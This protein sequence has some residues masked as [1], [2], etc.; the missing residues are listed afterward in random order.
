MQLK[1][2]FITLLPLFLSSVTAQQASSSSISA[3]QRPTEQLSGCDMK[4]AR[5]LYEAQSSKLSSASS[6]KVI[7][8][9]PTEGSTK[10]SD[11]CEE[12][13]QMTSDV[14]RRE[15]RRVLDVGKPA[16]IASDSNS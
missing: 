7:I 9:F 11:Q 12:S 16:Y 1:T 15:R 6:T 8:G 13:N 2:I 3:E 10:P 14:R 4:V 5:D